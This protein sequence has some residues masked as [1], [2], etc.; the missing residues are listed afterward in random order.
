MIRGR[1]APGAKAR[2]ASGDDGDGA[3]DEAPLTFAGPDAMARFLV[4]LL[5]L[6]GGGAFPLQFWAVH[7]L[8]GWGGVAAL[9]LLALVLIAG[10]RAEIVA[11]ATEVVITR[12][13]FLVPYR[14]YRG[15]SIDDVWYGGDWGEPEGALGV[16]V[17]LGTKE[18]HL[19]SPGTMHALHRALAARTRAGAG[20]S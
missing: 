3:R 9:A 17:R 18:I 10:L 1:I 7:R 16:V 4:A 8:A 11:S 15:P 6:G 19:G 12:R 2:A 5:L 20:R 14:R 13:W